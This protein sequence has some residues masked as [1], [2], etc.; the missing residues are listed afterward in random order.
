MASEGYKTK[1]SCRNGIASVRKNA[2]KKTRFDRHETKSG[3]TVRR[4]LLDGRFSVTQRCS[5]LG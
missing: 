2:T 5:R 1:A 4:H 3:Q